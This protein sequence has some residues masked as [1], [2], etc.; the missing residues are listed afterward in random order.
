M[1]IS[2]PLCFAN[3]HDP[4]RSDVTWDGISYVGTCKNCGMQIRRK[5]RHLWKLDD[6]KKSD[7]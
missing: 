1:A 3:R 7:G 2:I 5:K 4:V 6:H